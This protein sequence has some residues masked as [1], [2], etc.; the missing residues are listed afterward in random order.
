MPSSIQFSFSDTATTETCT[1]SL[2]D[3]LPISIP[4]DVVVPY[5]VSSPVVVPK[6]PGP[7]SEEDT[8]E[9]KSLRTLARS[10]LNE[11]NHCPATVLLGMTAGIPA[12]VGPPKFAASASL[13]LPA[14]I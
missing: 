7:S 2:H 3:A 14:R 9:L 10:L 5:W 6:A 12:A 13:I 11:K 8:S 1:L 4:N